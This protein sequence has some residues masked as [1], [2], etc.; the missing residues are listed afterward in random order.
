[1]N[2]KRLCPRA[3]LTER[4]AVEIYLCR[5]SSSGHKVSTS[6]LAEK[7]NISPKAIRDIWNRRTW[8]PETRHL[9]TE[10]ERPMIREKK[11]KTLFSPSQRPYHN[12]QPNN[13]IGYPTQQPF[14][15]TDFNASDRHSPCSPCDICLNNWQRHPSPTELHLAAAPRPD[16]YTL[17][18]AA[19]EKA[20]TFDV[21]SEWFR[22]APAML[23]PSAAID[24][25]A[26]SDE[27]AFAAAAKDDP[28]H[29]D[30]PHW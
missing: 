9:W 14:R 3:L 6:A 13:E 10:N 7:Y 19:L 23:C 5:R 12:F 17:S 2:T 21:D 25:G 8:A 20:I 16:A 29:F 15:F 4:E 30:W 18:S 28:F 26:E 27:A 22:D 11:T 24:C 1:M